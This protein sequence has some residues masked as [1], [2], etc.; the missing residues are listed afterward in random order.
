LEELK[1]KGNDLVLTRRFWFSRI[2]KIGLARQ[3]IFADDGSLES[4]IAYGNTGDFTETGEYKLPLRVDVVRP[5]EKYK[6]T[7][8]YYDPKAVIIG[9][10]WNEEIFTLKNRWKLTEVDLDKKVEEMKK[11]STQPASGDKQ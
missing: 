2:G 6:M 11:G 1:K 5:K 9:K 10:E 4:D 8:T 3:Q 7:L